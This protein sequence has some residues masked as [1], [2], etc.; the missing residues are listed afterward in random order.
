[1]K[2]SG[3]RYLEH[4]ADVAIEAWGSTREAM[5]VEAARAVIEVITE[6][7]VPR[8][9]AQR[10]ISIDAIDDEDRIVQWI[11]EVL[12]LAI[13]KGFLLADADVTLT[14]GGLRARIEGQSDASDI[15]VTEI[16][17]AT[18]HGLR[19]GRDEEGNHVA[20]VVLDV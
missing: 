9:D 6:G 15:V 11:N 10:E 13:G 18:Y 17:S 16:K 4:T 19:L 14:D 7:A 3:H 12:W 8:A 5:L 1:M 20:Q 2:A